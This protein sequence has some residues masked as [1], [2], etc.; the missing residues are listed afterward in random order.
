MRN[1]KNLFMLLIALGVVMFSAALFGVAEPVVGQSD[2]GRLNCDEAAPV[3]LYC[4][5]ES[6]EVYWVGEGGAIDL[7]LEVPYEALDAISQPDPATWIAGTDNGVVNVYVLD[8]WEIQ[9]NVF[10][11]DE[12]WVARWWDCPGGPAEVEVFSQVTGERLSREI[13]TCSM[14]VSDEVPYCDYISPY[15]AVPGSA[16]CDQ[17]CEY[18]EGG[19]LW[20]CDDLCESSDGLIP[21]GFLET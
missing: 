11:G 20:F 9:V 2:D 3:V 16:P 19:D 17:L 14:P 5:G 4:D 8:T 1:Q 6:L 10:N 21:C 15:S 12:L 18:G 13:D 7:V